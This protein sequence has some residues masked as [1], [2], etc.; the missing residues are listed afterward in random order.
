MIRSSTGEKE[1]QLFFGPP[2][3]GKSK[4]YLDLYDNI[5]TH[6]YIVDTDVATERMFTNR[7]Q[8][9]ATITEATDYITA[10]TALLKY[11]KIAKAGD[12]LVVDMITP[13]WG[14]CQD[15]WVTKKVKGAGDL[16]IWMPD[17]EIDYDWVA[18]NRLY[19]NFLNLILSC[20]AHVLVIA[21][22]DTLAKEGSKWENQ[23]DKAFATTGR[24]PR[25]N[26]R[27]PHLF[28]EVVHC[29]KIEM[30]EPQWRMTMAK[31]REGRECDW[32]RK[33]MTGLTFWEEYLIEVADWVEVAPPKKIR[34]VAK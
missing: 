4:A 21:E 23:A 17:K 13:T 14:W 31:E 16:A 27:V 33:D 6:M 30:A 2:G 22:E 19:N 5:D 34:R 11:N 15:Y 29:T 10:A 12:W 24:K 8:S 3:G 7:D 32:V 20:Q 26:K 28:H 25:G 18:I 9:R 1:R